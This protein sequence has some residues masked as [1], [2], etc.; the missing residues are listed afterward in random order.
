M[1][2]NKQGIAILGHWAVAHQALAISIALASISAHNSS[3]V[4]IDQAS[5][6]KLLAANGSVLP[7]SW[8]IMCSAQTASNAHQHA[9]IGHAEK[10]H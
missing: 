10:F 2:S 1:F 8:W 3:M 4:G 6:P 7:M 9:L 5:P